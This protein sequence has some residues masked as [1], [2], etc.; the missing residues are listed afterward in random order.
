MADRWI[1]SSHGFKQHKSLEAAQAEAL[2]LNRKTGKRFGLYRTKTHLQQSG[3]GPH[4]ARL[5]A[6]IAELEAERVTVMTVAPAQI[7]VDIA[8]AMATLKSSPELCH[9]LNRLVL[10]DVA[11]EALSAAQTRIAELEQ[12]IADY[13][14]TDCKPPVPPV[15]H[16]TPQKPCDCFPDGVTMRPELE[17]GERCACFPNW[18]DL[19]AKPYLPLAAGHAYVE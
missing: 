4:I 18:P 19:T 16:S 3:S 8:S 13:I 2:R 7:E 9:E 5:N 17:G 11:A 1:V 14:P 6:R 10:G 12:I 15:C